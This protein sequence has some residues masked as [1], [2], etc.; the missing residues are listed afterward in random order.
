MYS[1]SLIV[2][3]LER[4][5]WLSGRSRTV[6][7]AIS[8][9]LAV[10]ALLPWLI[11]SGLSWYYHIDYDVYRE[12]GRAFLEG[13]ELYTRLYQVEGID[14]PFTYPPLAAILFAPLAWIPLGLGSALLTVAT[15]V[16]LWWC[17]VLVVRHSLP[18]WSDQ[19]HRVIA[20]IV[21]PLALLAEPV[22]ET[23]SFGQVNILLMTL[24]LTDV[25]AR[26]TL[27][28]RGVLIGLAAA[29]KLT[30]AVFILI[31][32]VRRQWREAATTVASAV[33]VTLL[34]AL[35]S[36]QN[37]LTYWLDT[38]SDPGR[39]GGLAY[40]GNQSIRGMLTRL[41]DPEQTSS[42]LPW[43]VLVILA[44]A[45]IITAMVLV[46]R[47]AR[48]TD[49]SPDLGL[50]LLAS[51]AAL[52][53]SPVSWSHHW[54]WLVPFAVAL[55][56]AAWHAPKGTYRRLAFFLATGVTAVM[57][58]GPHWLLPRTNDVEYDWPWW[59]Q[60]LGNSYLV[61]AILI[62]ISALWAPSLMIPSRTG[63]EPE[64]TARKVWSWVVL[65]TFASLAVSLLV[66]IILGP[67]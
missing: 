63:V 11:T 65:A 32:F 66:R 49:A 27:L 34:A 51:L 20:T 24:V 55:A 25:L 45:T 39:I 48:N 53:C 14:L 23:L 17:V 36:P 64:T 6:V 33:A 41:S 5:A 19:D 7:V 43:L 22:R 67:L 21:L 60:L 13:Q 37:S 61:V 16:A 62:L 40:A 47:T 54:V 57:L 28:P 2:S 10:A 46:E 30:P 18:E 1:P 52:L 12:G 15:A 44:L 8:V 42:S 59:T 56:I 50:V 35:I 4:P 9:L 26:R 38:L 3:P 58:I 29:I 31:F